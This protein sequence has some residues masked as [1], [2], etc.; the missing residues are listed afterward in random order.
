VARAAGN[1]TTPDVPFI[2]T[3]I[4][5]MPRVAWQPA[6]QGSNVAFQALVWP[7]FT[8]FTLPLF[9]YPIAFEKRSKLVA[10]MSLAGM[11]QLPYMAAHYAF[12]WIVF[13]GVAG[14]YCVIGRAAGVGAFRNTGAGLIIALLFIWGHAQAGFGI[15]LGA[16]I[17]N[18][19]S[20]TTLSYVIVVVAAIASFLVF[21][22]ADPW[23]MAA[24]WVPFLSY[25]RASQL[26]LN[27]GGSS[28]APGSE[29]QWALLICVLH[30]TVA[31]ALGV[32]LHGVLPGPDSLA[33]LYGP[34][35]PCKA[36]AA[37]CWRR[38]GAA[39][40]PGG[41]G[42]GAPAE[43]HSAIA[44][45][46]VSSSS[47]S[48]RLVTTAHS[49]PADVAE[50][51]ARALTAL[52]GA[53]AVTLAGLTKMYGSPGGGRKGASSCGSCAE[54]WRTAVRAVAW[55]LAW[56]DVDRYKLAVDDL[57][58]AVPFGETLGLLGPNGAGKTT[59]I[60]MLTGVT[61]PTAGR[62]VLAGCD[63]TTQLGSAWRMTGVCPQFDTQ[64]DELTVEEHLRFFAQIKG[65]KW[66]RLRA[67]V[68]TVAER[69]NLDGDAFGQVG[70]R[71]GGGGGGGG[72]G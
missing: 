7:L 45:G 23:P 47:L 14:V 6:V 37:L 31:L 34:A 1:A 29:L 8:L 32:Y 24:T 30:G 52:P 49:E 13:V 21:Q 33:A 2:R 54:A 58:L 64:W 48:T 42:G 43:E 22:F 66:G 38:R 11:R 18:P 71:W 41:G 4:V 50:E 12:S 16:A 55:L 25:C 44:L 17:R 53:Y 70:R 40:R 72:I 67:T 59:T 46:P 63:V 57:A 51:R 69:V 62:A 9:V 61:R 5:R 3:A 19:R 10:M 68:R 26:I 15:L 36:I 60:S 56:E 20:A 39:P 65:V 27:Y 28:V 35:A